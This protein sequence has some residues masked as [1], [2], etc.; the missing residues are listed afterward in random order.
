MIISPSVAQILKGVIHE[1]NTSLKTGLEDPVKR[2]Q[3]D[4]MIGVL[5]SCAVRTEHETDWMLKEVSAIRSAAEK[6]VKA[7]HGARSLRSSQ[8][9]FDETASPAKQYDAASNILSL[10]ADAGSDA[11][12]ELSAEVLA[13]MELRL[14]H[15]G[16][17]IGGGFEAAGRS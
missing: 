11:G 7:G 14:E 3:I 13:L 10:M 6:F 1:M 15:E 17:I 9:S 5:S 12:T 16:Y 4:T 8:S 2:A